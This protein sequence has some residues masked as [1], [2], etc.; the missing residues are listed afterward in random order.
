[1]TSTPILMN[2]FGRQWDDVR[3]DA[4]RAFD[5]VGRSG[6]YILG[7]QVRQFETA[8]GAS[9][10]L[11]HAI[12]VA[13]GLDGIELALRAAGLR[14]GDRVLTTPLSAFATTLAIV[15]PGGIPVFCDTTETGLIDLDEARAALRAMPGIRYFVPVHLYGFPLD[16]A[17]LR[18]LI[19]EFDLVCVE[20][21]AQSIGAEAGGIATGRQGVAAVTSFY[22]TKN[23]GAMGDGGAVLTSDP[24]LAN[25]V[26]CLRDYGQTAKYKHSEL[27][28][29]SRLDEVHA[30]LLS[31]AFLPRL[32]G[33]TE[34]RRQIAAR[35]LTHWT[36]ERVRPLAPAGWGSSEWRPCWHLFPVRVRAAEKASLMAWL[37]SDGI[38]TGEHYPILIPNQG[39]LRAV[40]SSCFG[41]LERAELLSTEELSLPIHPYLA[42]EEVDRVLASIARWEEVG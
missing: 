22:P 29:N 36:S 23:L 30:A 2:D 17:G 14:A 24:L 15:R 33:W 39:A 18:S 25:R 13:S 7:S 9:W 8:L 5:A 38:G 11:A 20:D 41:A 26:R 28:L 1:M 27:G 6:W 3:D 31:G 40:S 34:R 16:S 42:D 19:D 32:A 12:G 10:G 21:C 37:R 35:Y 4:L